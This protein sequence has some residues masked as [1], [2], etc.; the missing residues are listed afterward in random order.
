MNTL[1]LS[2]PIS[3]IQLQAKC[4]QWAWNTYPKTRKLLAHVPNGGSRNKIE[5]TQLKASGVVEGVHDLFFYWKGQLYWFE[6][7]V[8]KNKQSP[9]QIEFGQA[10]QAQGAICHEVRTLEQFQDLFKS[11]ISA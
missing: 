8:G 9:A 3:E 5:A 7:K 1:T 6:L 11:I 10:M 2:A 4:F